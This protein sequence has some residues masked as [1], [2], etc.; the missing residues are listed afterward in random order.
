MRWMV[1]VP[2]VV[3]ALKAYAADDRADAKQLAYCMMLAGGVMANVPQDAPRA[4]AMRWVRQS[5]YYAD[6]LE[7]LAPSVDERKALM[8]QATAEI[9]A[10]N[11]RL[12]DSENLLFEALRKSDQAFARCTDIVLTRKRL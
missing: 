7:K 5:A 1:L 11:G 4:D 8:D 2:C 3:V 9:R 6:G 10:E 12:R